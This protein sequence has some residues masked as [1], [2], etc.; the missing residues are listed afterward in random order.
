[1]ASLTQPFA[2]R[3]H[4]TSR[5]AAGVDAVPFLD[6]ILIALFAGLNLSRFVL[7]PGIAVQL[8]TSSSRQILPQ[9]PAA[10]LTVDRNQLYFFEGGK[11]TAATLE[12]RLRDYLQQASSRPTAQPGAVLVIKADASIT[13]ETLF[14]LMD[15][16]REAGFTQVHLAA[17]SAP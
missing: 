10:V 5:P 12:T 16:A 9:G 1:M 8:P 14:W 15:L 11:F 13:A 2:F 6:L 7:A 4:L 3:N 17:E